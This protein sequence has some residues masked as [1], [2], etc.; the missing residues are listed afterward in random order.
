M[1]FD[2]YCICGCLLCCVVYTIFVGRC[3]CHPCTGGPAYGAYGPCRHPDGRWIRYLE[4]PPLPYWLVAI[5]FKLFGFNAFATHLPEALAVL[6]CAI[7][8]LLWGRRA[9]SERAAFYAALAF[10]TSIGTFLFTRYFIPESILTLLIALALYLFLT[11]LED[12]Q[13]AR[14][15]CT[16]ALLGLLCSPRD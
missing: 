6:G 15:Y 14:M 8:A 5:D 1:D 4:K 2:S 11:G 16:Y 3:R 7:L 13:P 12:R 9:Y 10:L